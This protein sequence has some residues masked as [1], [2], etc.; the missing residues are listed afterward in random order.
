MAT[1]KELVEALRVRYALT[2]LWEAADRVCGKRLKALIA[3]LVDAM[4]RHEHLALDPVVRTQVLQVSAATIDRTLAN[5]RSP[6]RARVST[7]NASAAAAWTRHPAQHSSVHVCR[8]GGIRSSA[9]LNASR[10]LEMAHVP[11]KSEAP[12]AQDLAGGIVPW[13][14]AASTSRT[15]SRLNSRV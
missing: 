10:G 11:Y 12:F 2:M 15:A 9:Y 8:L 4:E 13:G 1:R 3:T 14:I 6:M 5:A 7:S